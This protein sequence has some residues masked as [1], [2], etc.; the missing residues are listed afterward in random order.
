M[1]NEADVK[2]KKSNFSDTQQMKAARSK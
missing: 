1:N 2:I